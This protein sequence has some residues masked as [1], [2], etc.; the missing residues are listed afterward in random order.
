MMLYLIAG[1]AIGAIYALIALG[2]VVIYRSSQVFNFAQGELVML[3]A[4]LTATL[5]DLMPWPLAVLGALLGTGLVALA[6]ERTVL[7]KLVGRP[8]YVSIIL[9]II[10]GSVI[11]IAVLLIWGTGTRG[12]PTPWDPLADVSLGSLEIS[13]NNVAALLA[14]GIALAGYFVLIRYTKFGLSMRASSSD[15]ESALSLGIPVGRVFAG[16]WFLAGVFAAIAGVFLAMFPR[17]VEPNLGLI[18]LAAFPA[19]IVGGLD[20]ALGTV[21]AA[22]VLGVL[23][24][25]TEAYLN[26]LLGGFGQNFHAVFP[27]VVMIAFLLVRPYGLF[28]TVDVQRV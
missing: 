16:T 2:F 28:G 15:Q 14:A 12:M 8:V 26:P 4:Y 17:S 20:S 1:L 27:Y 23:Q 21:I 22:L 5:A 13:V 9:T 25:L 19:V 11:R 6:I 18:A 7:R 24:V 3:G 10:V